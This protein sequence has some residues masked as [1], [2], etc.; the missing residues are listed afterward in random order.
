RDGQI[1]HLE[2]QI[3]LTE[4]RNEKLQE[5]LDLLISNAA[6]HERSG[7]EPPETL[8]KD[9][10]SL[11]D[12]ISANDNYIKVKR[13]EQDAIKEQFDTDIARFRKLSGNNI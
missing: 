13:T 9:I 12:Q 10:Q 4:N 2:S 3:K 7:K 8:L 11:E 1:A 6:N 5:N